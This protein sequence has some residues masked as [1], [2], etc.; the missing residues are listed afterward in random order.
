MP[1]PAI[2][3][4][5]I[6][7]YPSHFS[8][9]HHPVSAPQPPPAP[10]KAARQNHPELLYTPGF[11]RTKG[12]FLGKCSICGNTN[13]TMAWLFRAGPT[14]V[15][16]P[17][18]PALMESS[19]PAFPLA[20]GNFPETDILSAGICCESCS[21]FAVQT[22]M[23]SS[24]EIVT[25]ALPMVS[26]AENET[27]IKKTLFKVLGGWFDPE[28]VTQVFLSILLSSVD[29]DVDASDR[30]AKLFQRAIQWACSDIIYSSTCLPEL[31]LAFS[32]SQH[33]S[34]LQ[35]LSEVLKTSF[36]NINELTSCVMRYPVDGFIVVVRAAA[37][38]DVDVKLRR[39]AVF[40]RLLYLL[41]ETFKRKNISN[42]VLKALLQ[43]GASQPRPDTMTTDSIPESLTNLQSAYNIPIAA[44]RGSLILDER[45]YRKL[46][47]LQD[48]NYLTSDECTWVGP[49]VAAFLYVLA[50]LQDSVQIEEPWDLF[51]AITNQ[52]RLG[53]ISV[54]PEDFTIEEASEVIQ[55]FA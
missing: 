50:A 38:A 54:R 3:L 45:V 55:A 17:G 51:N 6:Y 53:G 11:K 9:P 52:Y 14:N 15:K 8:T 16:T 27:A 30:E 36:D 10:K 33:P 37:I 34:Q 29:A 7:S 49:A 22:K 46:E 35:Q 47:G 12:S 1:P 4:P 48:F 40:R 42:N 41:I 43:S 25:G 23:S 5:S 20:A 32:L 28:Y 13:E 24:D 19:T 31:S 2:P 26:Y 44:L 21:W 18:F 39:R